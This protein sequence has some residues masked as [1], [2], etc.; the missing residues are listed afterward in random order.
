MP[1]T[2]G[3]S[4]AHDGSEKTKSRERKWSLKGYSQFTGKSNLRIAGLSCSMTSL[5]LRSIVLSIVI[6]PSSFERT[7][8]PKQDASSG[9]LSS[10]TKLHFLSAPV[11]LLI[12]FVYSAAALAKHPCTMAL[13]AARHLTTT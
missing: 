10:T 2:P 6:L 7:T 4:C 12:S 13:S 9:D 8:P 3:S 1:T 5:S 11:S